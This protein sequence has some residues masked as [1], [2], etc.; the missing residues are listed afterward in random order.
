MNDRKSV[1]HL[2]ADADVV[3]RCV[4]TSAFS[5]TCQLKADLSLLPI[6]LHPA[7]AELCIQ[8]HKHLVTA[9]YISNAMKAL[10]DR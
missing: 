9:S 7:A 3:I 6:A 10:H 5:K 4:S 8:H 2:I 1:S